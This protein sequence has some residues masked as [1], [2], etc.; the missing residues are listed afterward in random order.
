MDCCTLFFCYPVDDIELFPVWDLAVNKP[1][2][3]GYVYKEKYCLTYFSYVFDLSLDNV[4]IW[5]ILEVQVLSFPV[6][7]IEPLYRMLDNCSGTEL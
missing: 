4:C 6:L 2:Y 3:Y 7:S 1:G 5:H